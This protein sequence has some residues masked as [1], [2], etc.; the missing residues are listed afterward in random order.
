MQIELTVNGQI[1]TVEADPRETLL[2]VLRE[3][4]GMR[5]TKYGC[6]E[7]E[8]GACTVIIN[9]RPVASC[10]VPAGQAHGAELLTI[11]GMVLDP[12]GHHLLEAF[13][14]RG[15]VQCGYCS[16]GF[17]ISARA[18]LAKNTS[19]TTAEIQEALAGNLCRCT[20]YTKIIDAIHLAAEQVDE[21]SLMSDTGPKIAPAGGITDFA[22]TATLEEALTLL[23]QDS[24]KIL[25]GGTDVGV[26]FEHRMQTWRWLDLSGVEEL[27]TIRLEKDVLVIGGGVTYT[28]LIES[29]VVQRW[30]RPLVQ[31]A[32]TVGSRQ[33][34]NQGTLA[35]NLVN[36]SPAADAV[37]PL[38]ALNATAVLLSLR[39]ERQVLVTDLATGPGHTLLAADEILTQIRIP[40]V[41]REE[42][43]ISFFDKVG[44]RKAQTIAI[45]SVALRG[46]LN[47][48]NNRFDG[49]RIALGAVAPTVMLASQAA[50][51][52]MAGPLTEARLLE[53]GEIAARECWPIDDLRGSASY[54]RRLVRGLLVRGLWPHV[55]S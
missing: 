44:P 55:V 19:P 10:L 23:A 16:P 46:W 4:L 20:G 34:Q 5:G 37:P 45:A 52:L 7:G 28:D 18:L 31:A 9:G 1:H 39:G 40:R 3:H 12:I 36:A 13:S 15:A 30:A 38:Y 41:E 42:P 14:E 2:F 22:R 48:G 8:C 33:I 27:R 17:V 51:H 50:E 26:E 25:C 11:E 54:R 24:W 6:G 47:P 29:A 49:L 21:D 32:K 43:E 35:G 53:A